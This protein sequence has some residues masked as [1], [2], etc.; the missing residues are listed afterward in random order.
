[1]YKRDMLTIAHRYIDV[2]MKRDH[3]SERAP[4]PTS[5]GTLPAIFHGHVKQADPRYMQGN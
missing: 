3:N 1:M 5:H 2:I 4:P